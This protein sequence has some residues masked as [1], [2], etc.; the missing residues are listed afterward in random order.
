MLSSVNL[1]LH[2]YSQLCCVPKRCCSTAVFICYNRLL[3]WF[4]LKK[5]TSNFTILLFSTND[6]SYHL[7]LNAAF[8]GLP[9]SLL[10]FFLISM[11]GIYTILTCPKVIIAA[12]FSL[13]KNRLVHAHSAVVSQILL[14]LYKSREMLW[15]DRALHHWFSSSYKHKR[16]WI[17]RYFNIHIAIVSFQVRCIPAY[18]FDQ[19]VF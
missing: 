10:I 2:K 7:P 4:F 11:R 13:F 3:Y 18:V 17:F 15:S 1:L 19:I 9:A 12:N 6:S 8:T 14:N 5:S 16:I